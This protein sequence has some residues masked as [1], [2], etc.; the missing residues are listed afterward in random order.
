MNGKTNQ[1]ITEVLQDAW[2]PKQTDSQNAKVC[3]A[4]TVADGGFFKS[5]A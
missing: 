4:V 5:K 2:L 1:R 3:K